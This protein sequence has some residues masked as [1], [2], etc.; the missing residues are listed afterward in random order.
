MLLRAYG[1]TTCMKYYSPIILL[2]SRLLKKTLFHMVYMADV[3]ILVE[4]GSPTWRKANFIDTPKEEQL[5]NDAPLVEEVWDM[6]QV[7]EVAKNQRMARRFNSKVRP[8]S[9]R[10]GDLALKKIYD[11]IKRGEN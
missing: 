4:V 2:H 9:F 1:P 3:M 10:E 6:T 8:K 7:K 5:E 11:T